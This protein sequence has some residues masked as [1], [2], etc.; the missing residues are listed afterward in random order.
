LIDPSAPVGVAKLPP[1]HPFNVGTTNYWSS[2]TSADNGD[3]AWFVR[4]A[5]GGVMTVLKNAD[6]RAWCVRGGHGHD[7]R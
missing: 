7:A 1:G 3:A 2:T 4:L 5:S 6:F